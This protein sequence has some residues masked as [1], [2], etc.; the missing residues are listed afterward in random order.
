MEDWRLDKN[1]QDFN[2]IL[3]KNFVCFDH[4]TLIKRGQP[5]CISKSNLSS[6]QFNCNWWKGRSY[7]QGRVVD[8]NDNDFYSYINLTKN[9]ELVWGHLVIFQIQKVIWEKSI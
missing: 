1:V 6:F 4:T 9:I 5:I 2:K 7:L 8:I 3:C